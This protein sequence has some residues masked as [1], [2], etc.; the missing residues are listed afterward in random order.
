MLANLTLAQFQFVV[1]SLLSSNPDNWVGYK[2][3]DKGHGTLLLGRYWHKEAGT[4]LWHMQVNLGKAYPGLVEW[5]SANRM[6]HRFDILD[7]PAK[8]RLLREL[9]SEWFGLPQ[10]DRGQKDAIGRIVLNMLR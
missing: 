5:D 9:M 7:R 4:H 1:S 6:I 3:E 2:K 10:L 8:E